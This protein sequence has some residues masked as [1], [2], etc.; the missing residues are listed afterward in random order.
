MFTSLDAARGAAK[1][2]KAANGRDE[3]SDVLVPRYDQWHEPAA[4]E[5]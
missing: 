5:A 1:R 4:C 3:A 2:L